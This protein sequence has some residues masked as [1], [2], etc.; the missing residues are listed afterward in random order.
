MAVT[1][2]SIELDP[3]TDTETAEG[4]IAEDLVVEIR[5][6]RTEPSWHMLRDAPAAVVRRAENPSRRLRVRRLE[7]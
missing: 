3:Q 2:W 4:P 6:R 5:R 7:A 1:I